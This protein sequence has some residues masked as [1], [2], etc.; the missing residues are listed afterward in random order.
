MNR[1]ETHQLY[2]FGG[3]R[4]DPRRRV[5]SRLDGEVIA[6]KPKVFDTLL[7]LV[8]HAGEL[9]DKST[10]LAAIW[11][12]LIVEES[13]LN[14]NISTL[15]RVL[16]E[17]PEDHRFIVTEPGRGYR[18]VAKVS[19]TE[20][21]SGGARRNNLHSLVTGLL[22]AA[23]VALVIVNYSSRG[24]SV[25]PP[26]TRFQIEASR[27]LNPLNIA[28]SPDGR[29][30]AYVGAS[31]FGTAIWVRHLSSLE[32]RPLP[33]TEG[34]TETSYPFWSADGRYIA[35]RSVLDLQ[36]VDVASGATSTITGNMTLFRRGAWGPDGTILFAIA[37]AIHRVPASGG[38]PITVTKID[39]SL[40]EI[41]HSAP[42]FLPDGRHFLYKAT[43][44]NRRNG[45]IYVGSLNPGEPRVRLLEASRAIYVEPGFLIFAR[46]QTLFARAF[47]PVRLELKGPAVQIADGLVYREI[48]DTTAF[49]ASN[50]GTLIFRRAE[51]E[52]PQ[53]PLMWVDRAGTTT[54]AEISIAPVNFRLS[55]DGTRIAFAEGDPPD[56]WTIDIERGSRT[57]LTADPQVDHNAIWSPDGSFIA[58]DS[59]RNGGRSIYEKRADGAVAE[60]L[61]LEAGAHDVKVTDWSADG[62]FIVFEKDACVGCGYDIWVLPMSG[63]HEPFA[64]TNTPFDERAARLSPDG[65]WLAYSTSESGIY[66]VVVQSFP[67]PAQGKWQISANGGS[68]PQWARDGQELYYYDVTGSI[69]RVQVATDAV[70]EVG[71]A[72]RVSEA[73]AAYQWDVTADGGRLLKTAP[74]VMDS[75]TAPSGAG[76]FPITVILNWPSLM[77]N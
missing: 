69:V 19:V 7:H 54:A 3:F 59:H 47:D 48:L 24:T 8:E 52:G 42:W 6:L 41:A 67:D 63:D 39:A 4:V 45:A 66:E 13:N 33:G 28:L 25:R 9:L 64:Y 2:E 5:L 57:R 36:Y 1:L 65:R 17:A 61:L 38:E 43:N 15:R 49:D 14:K 11:P 71:R 75:P 77:E 53:V 16:G 72:V 20:A 18:F 44:V 23:V 56:I 62:R 29:Q 74:A 58:F 22:A 26:E 31:E 32:A 70:F 35:F 73:A 55:P 40:G 34:V 12:N 21:G 68:G 50:E 76:R 27:T 51:K 37:D 10:L 30:I 60:R 46:E